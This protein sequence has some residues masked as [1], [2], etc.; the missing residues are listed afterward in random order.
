MANVDVIRRGEALRQRVLE[1]RHKGE[2]V[3]FVPTMGY[4]HEGHLSLVRSARQANRRVV[5]SIFVNPTQFV[6][7]EDF[8]RYP[9]DEARDLSLLEEEGVDWVLIPPPEEVYPAGFSTGIEPP[10]AA[11]GWE[12]AHRPGHFAG[13][14]TVV[15]ILFQLVQ[16]DRAYF[17][18]KDAQQLAVIRQMTRDFRLPIEIIEGETIREPDGLAMS[19]RNR[20]LD[21]QQ[22]EQALVLSR[23]LRRV[24]ERFRDGVRNAR[25]LEIEAQEMIEAQ[26][27]VEL[28]Y[29]GVVDAQTFV[30]REEAQP[31][32]L[33]IGAIRLPSARLIDNMV[34]EHVSSFL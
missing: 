19:S 31:G 24:L 11:E 25:Q 34:L 6:A 13:V 2:T 30:I 9:R 4:L 7:G 1:A 21:A 32:D 15:L 12:G 3:G 5:V 17:G 29:V 27:G 20:Y 14:C 33:V 22:R 16:P 23:A 28:D 26:P 18:R 8:D 10:S